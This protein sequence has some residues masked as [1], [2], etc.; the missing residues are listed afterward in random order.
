MQATVAVPLAKREE[1]GG[2]IALG[3]SRFCDL[4]SQ[5]DERLGCRR[6][7]DTPFANKPT[8]NRNSERKQGERKGSVSQQYSECGAG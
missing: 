2:V 4:G 6:H 7:I 5:G 8:A 1:R 3:L